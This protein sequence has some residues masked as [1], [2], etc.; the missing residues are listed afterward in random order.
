MNAAKACDPDRDFMA[1]MI[2][3]HQG[4]IDMA[5]VLLSYGKDHEV[6]RLSEGIV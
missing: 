6:R 3:H 5:K 4:A 2:P 1:I